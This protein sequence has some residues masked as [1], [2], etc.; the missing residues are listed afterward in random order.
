MCAKKD[1]IVV[2]PGDLTPTEMIAGWK[3]GSDLVKI[4]PTGHA[5]GGEY[6]RALK[7]AIT[8]N[9]LDRNGR[10]MKRESR[11]TGARMPLALRQSIQGPW[12]QHAIF[13]NTICTKLLK[14]AA[15][16]RSTPS[17]AYRR[18]RKNLNNSF[19]FQKSRL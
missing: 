19:H 16:P 17:Q 7:G 6:V 15:S 4:F 10:Q 5:G 18:F 3:A 11:I 1:E 9:S 14:Q 13:T 2:L 8:A 12:I